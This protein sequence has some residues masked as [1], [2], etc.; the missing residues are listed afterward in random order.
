VDH[1]SLS[2]P[3]RIE[4]RLRTIDQ[5]FNSMDLS[6]FIERDLAHEAEEFIVSWALE[7]PRDASLHLVLH[8]RRR[9]PSTPR[10]GSR[11]RSTTTSPTARASSASSCASCCAAAGPA[12]PSACCS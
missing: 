3:G 1:P 6:P 2:H 8:I 5:L 11:R 9:S 7:H 10:N 4:L 12:S